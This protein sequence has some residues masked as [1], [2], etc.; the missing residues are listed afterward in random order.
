MISIFKTPE[1]LVQRFARDFFKSADDFY[2][3]NHVVHVALSGGTTPK[4]WFAIL[5]EQYHSLIHWENIHFYWS[6]ERMVPPEDKESNYGEAKRILFDNISIS[7]DNIHP[8]L[9][10]REA[11]SEL[12]RYCHVLQT[13]LPSNNNRPIFDIMILGMGDDGHTASL[14]PDR[15]D[16]LR[17]N[18]LVATVF[19]PLIKQRR[20]T[21]TGP[22]INNARHIVFLITGAAKAPV[23]AEILKK[24]GNCRDYPA[25]YVQPVS[26]ELDFYIDKEAAAGL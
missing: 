26:G 3:R 16:L 24:T 2:L 9:G 14:F 20:I 1:L 21:L 5:K 17:S 25:A 7:S 22:V 8:V 19:H 13:N 15:M 23:L 6:D 4:R 12:Q 10:D 11:S 18:E